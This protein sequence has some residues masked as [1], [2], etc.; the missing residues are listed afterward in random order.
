MNSKRRNQKLLVLFMLLAA[1]I[2]ACERPLRDT[3]EVNAPD[4]SAQV[5]TTDEVAATPEPEVAESDPEDA[6]AADTEADDAEADDAAADDTETDDTSGEDMAEAEP[7]DSEATSD[8]AAED[9]ASE[10]EASEGEGVDDSEEVT[11]SADDG[12]AVAGEDKPEEDKEEDAA[13][14]E[15]P[16]QDEGE[17]TEGDTEEDAVEG[18]DSTDTAD[19]ETDAEEDT[20]E[21]AAE[22]TAEDTEEDTAED[23]ADTAEDDSEDTA[24]ADETQTEEGDETAATEEQIH[25]I[26][27]GENLYQIGLQYGISWVTLAEYNNLANPND[28]EAGQTLRIPP[29]G[30]GEDDGDAGDDGDD[31]VAEEVLYVVQFGDTLNIIGARYGVSW[32]QIAEANGIVNPN[33]IFAG[34]TLKIPVDSPGPQ[35]EFTHVVEPGE[36]LYLISLQY[37][38]AWP[39]IAEANS[40]TAP[41][42]IYYGQSLIIPGGE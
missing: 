26:R 23:S 31:D 20:A 41:Y 19:A 8:D 12:D 25:V 30:G 28:I 27:A 37:G 7:D 38:V 13:E 17:E 18:D 11:D 33:Q 4:T 14:D 1:L 29:A 40:L 10:D 34:Q 32:V 5:D 24:A 16:R 42:V 2:V 3:S 9:D 21:D 15:S 6:P 36:T 35:P 39:A 22:E